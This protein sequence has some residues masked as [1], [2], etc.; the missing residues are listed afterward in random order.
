MEGSL[1]PTNVLMCPHTCVSNL[2]KPRTK[3]SD[4]GPASIMMGNLVA[5]SRIAGA[6]G[7][8]IG[9]PDEE[10]DA[11]KKVNISPLIFNLDKSVIIPVMTTCM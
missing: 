4:V 2:P 1:H 6:A 7:R 11:A 5:G 3:Q 9:R 10:S 8:D